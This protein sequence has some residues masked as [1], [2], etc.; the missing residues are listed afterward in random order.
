[1]AV[2]HSRG[3]GL[4]KPIP[5]SDL[6]FEKSQWQRRR[7]EGG[8]KGRKPSS[9]KESSA[10]F[11]DEDVAALAEPDA[12]LDFMVPAGSTGKE[13]FLSMAEIASCSYEA[14]KV[15]HLNSFIPENR[16]SG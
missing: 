4:S 16:Y 13:T 8:K 11:D 10:E 2:T 15:G 9:V 7:E 6:A 12:E 14:R 3:K 5:G 1:M